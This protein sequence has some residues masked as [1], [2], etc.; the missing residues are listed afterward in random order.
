[1]AGGQGPRQ[2]MINLMYLVFIAMLALN[3][4][5]EVLTAFGLIEEEMAENNAVMSERNDAALAGLE[6]KAADQASFRKAAEAA[7]QI[8]K[9]T[10]EFDNYLADLKDQMMESVP[11]DDRGD[12]EVQDKADFLN[13]LFFTGDKLKPEG[14]K[15]L[16]EMD[17]Y[18]TDMLSALGDL[19]AD[20][21]Y[22]FSD[23]KAQIQEKYNTDP[24]RSEMDNPNSPKINYLKYHYEGYPLIASKTKMTQLQ[25]GVKNIEAEILG[26]LLAGELIRQTSADT[27]TAM[28]IPDKSAYFSGETFTGK[29]VLGKYD[30]S[31]VPNEV[32][33]NGETIGQENI[34]NGQVMLEFPAGSIG[35]K[36]IT[37]ELKFQQGDSIVPLEVKG[38]YVVVPKPQNAIISADKMNVVYRGVDNPMTVTF[39]GIP[40][41]KVN[42]SAPGLSGTGG[43]S[44]V[45][46]PGSGSKVTINVTGELPTGEKVSDQKTFRIKDLPRPTGTI[47]G[48]YENVKMQR[49]RLA[50]AE[51][52]AKFLDFDFDL[53]PQVRS[54]E[55]K[56]PG[57]P[58]V[59]VNGTRFSAAAK[60][61]L[62]QARRADVIQISNINA[63]VPGVNLSSVAP[64]VVELTN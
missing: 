3:M 5:K 43:S 28:V 64:V 57:Q 47:A 62:N 6:A 17:Q 35:E 33:I 44:Y 34:V 58:T 38:N 29:V 53:N 46:K 63:V 18:R 10:E 60:N 21:T 1:M 4:S 41:N 59:R 15:F 52:D 13:N 61:A 12:Y 14:E 39:A 26:K 48:E 2:K 30:S 40:Q 42:A 7:Q 49:Q 54:F 51:V 55:V 27:F 32:V 36:D 31:L 45:M 19:N 25:N 22:D 11:E 16:K 23:I 20:K 8:E 56:V 50:I 24:V 37:G 9:I